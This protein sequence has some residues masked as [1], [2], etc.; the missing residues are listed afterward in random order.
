MDPLLMEAGPFAFCGVKRGLLAH[1]LPI[2]VVL[3]VFH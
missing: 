2:P 3:F 1:F